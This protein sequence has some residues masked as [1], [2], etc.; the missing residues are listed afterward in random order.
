MEF[1]LKISGSGR[2]AQERGTAWMD[3]S[4]CHELAK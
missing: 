4:A 1:D 2:R 3:T